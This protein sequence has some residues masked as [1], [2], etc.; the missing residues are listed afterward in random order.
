[1]K[2]AP[3]LQG[4]RD[5]SGG[6][7]LA[8][9]LLWSSLL[10]LPL[11]LLTGCQGSERADLL[12]RTEHDGWA[13]TTTDSL[14]FPVPGH[15]SGERRIFINEV[16]ERVEPPSS[17]EEGW[18]YPQGTVILKE[19]YPSPD[20]PQDAPPDSLAIMVKQPDHPM[21][22]GGWV[23]IVKQ[24]GS[25]EERIFTEQFCITCH[26][27]ANEKHPYGDGNAREEFRDY[28]FYPY[29]DEQPQD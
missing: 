15:G 17:R 23:W 16:G 18:D 22:R 14:S 4:E 5:R 11:L 25:G 28:V 9:A 13:R 24:P 12:V 19:V 2:N 20:P 10:L 27:N 29:S 7:R 8:S 26:A 21:S 1:M 6:S 3:F